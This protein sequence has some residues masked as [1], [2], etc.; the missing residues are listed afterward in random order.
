MMV[1]EGWE[2]RWGVDFGDLFG[3]RGIVMGMQVRVR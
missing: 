3:E 2:N 1:G